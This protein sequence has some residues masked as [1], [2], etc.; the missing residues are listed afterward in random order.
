M[1]KYKEL[2]IIQGILAGLR[3]AVVALIAT[4]GI[5]IF[6]LAV[7]GENGFS[8]DPHT[9]NVIALLLFGGSLFIL[10]KWKPSPILVMFGCG[11]V[12]GIIYL[13]V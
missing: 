10:R 6:T 5:S 4:A 1:V 3:P 2:S 11:L 13:I 8:F 12:G 9:I 7:W